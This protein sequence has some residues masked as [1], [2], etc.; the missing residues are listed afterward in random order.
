M[1]PTTTKSATRL[2]TTKVGTER[3][4]EIRSG[5]RGSKLIGISSRLQARSPAD[6]PADAA[7][8]ELLLPSH[9][10]FAAA[11]MIDLTHGLR[12]GPAAAAAAVL[13]ALTLLS[14]CAASPPEPE[15]A[16]VAPPPPPPPA[17]PPLDLA[18][19][20]KLTAAGSGGCMMNFGA[21]PAAVQ[22]T[23]APEGGCP[24]KFFTSRKWTFEHNVLIVRDHKGE[25][26]AQLSFAG[27]G[28]VGQG[29]GGGYVS[30]AR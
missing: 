2:P 15:P 28:F 12:S 13:L 20:W 14:G 23:I 25:P 8:F 5:R 9:F 19:R 22:G 3:R 18:G 16:A 7:A 30:L 10:G 1:T 17:P 27:G 24:G 26:L 11:R 21:A 29:T 4:A 6:V